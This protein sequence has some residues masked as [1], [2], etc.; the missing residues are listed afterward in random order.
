M[1]PRI[2]IAGIFAA[3]LSVYN[4][5][6]QT[7]GS[8]PMPQDTVR[9][10]TVQLDTV[11]QNTAQMDSILQ[12]TALQDTVRQDTVRASILR[13]ILTGKGPDGEPAKDSVSVSV[14]SDEEWPW[15]TI[16]I[17]AATGKEVN[18]DTVAVASPASD[19][20]RKETAEESQPDAAFIAA[21][22]YV[23]PLNDLVEFFKMRRGELSRLYAEWA[24]A[25]K[26]EMDKLELAA[27]NIGQLEE[28][29]REKTYST[30]KAYSPEAGSLMTE[31]NTERAKAKGITGAILAEKSKTEAQLREMEKQEAKIQADIF[32]KA[33][34]NIAPAAQSPAESR[35]KAEVYFS[36]KPQLHSMAG[37]MDP[38]NEMVMWYWN[39]EQSL[40]PGISLWNEKVSERVEADKK[41]KAQIDEMKPYANDKT[42][43][44]NISQ[45]EKERKALAKSMAADSKELAKQIKGFETELKAAYKERLNHIISEMNHIAS[46]RIGY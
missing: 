2:A 46:D 15:K 8:T 13:D 26:A 3:L 14:I 32:K 45:L 18:T 44:K 36:E 42:V 24:L 1:N 41:L 22:D 4:A 9:Q 5:G 21:M 38:L 16:A 29:V 33:I 37:Y 19:I 6:A 23:A 43:K 20:V 11:L 30:Y 17:D 10:N 7:P 39:V 34:K 12:S 31:L 27:R 28:E 25:P 35:A 40:R